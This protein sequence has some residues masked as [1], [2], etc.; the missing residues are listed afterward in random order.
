MEAVAI[1]EALTNELRRSPTTS[2]IAAR[3]GWS[4]AEATEALS[5]HAY[6]TCDHTDAYNDSTDYRFGFVETGFDAF[7]VRD[8]RDRMLAKLSARDRRMVILRTDGDLPQTEIARRVGL[9]Q[10]HVSRRLRLS[11]E[12]MRSA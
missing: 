12:M 4:E 7:D 2:E 11:A 10:M 5:Q 1:V 9:S 6:R 8:Q 3:G